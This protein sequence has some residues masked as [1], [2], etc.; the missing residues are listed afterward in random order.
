MK[1]ELVIMLLIALEVQNM[2]PP[3]PFSAA[4]LIKEESIK[5][6]LIP[7]QKT[8]PPSVLAVL[9]VK[10]E[11]IKLPLSLA[12]KIPPPLTLAVLSVKEEHDKIPLRPFQ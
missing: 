7:Y 9:L 2:P 4:L 1:V 11:L 12:Q 8:A 3:L 10:E 5:L 6:P